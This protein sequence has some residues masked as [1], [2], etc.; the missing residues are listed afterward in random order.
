M[1]YWLPEV[2]LPNNKTNDEVYA[3]LHSSCSMARDFHEEMISFKIHDLHANDYA[4]QKIN[5]FNSSIYYF[6]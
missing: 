2:H 4:G 6:D 1:I 3:M 5:R